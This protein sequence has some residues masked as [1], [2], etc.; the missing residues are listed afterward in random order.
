MLITALLSRRPNPS[1]KPLAPRGF[2]RVS[3]GFRGGFPR[4]HG[5]KPPRISPGLR[6]A[7]SGRACAIAG[8]TEEGGERSGGAVLGA[9]VP[10][11]A[12]DMLPVGPGFLTCE[13]SSL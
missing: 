10:D 1:S 4:C 3:R 7:S 9:R 11:N 6:I 12:S 8:Q 5:A 2:G 13:I